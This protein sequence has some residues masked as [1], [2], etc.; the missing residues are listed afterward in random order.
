MSLLPRGIEI[1]TPREI[2]DTFPHPLL[3]SHHGYCLGVDVKPSTLLLWGRLAS[4]PWGSR[5]CSLLTRSGRSVLPLTRNLLCTSLSILHSR[6][7]PRLV[8]CRRYSVGISV[9]VGL[10]LLGLYLW[11]GKHQLVT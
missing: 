7:A 6:K 1:S 8:H 4:P 10:G 9:E 3:F 5:S 2:I 11:W